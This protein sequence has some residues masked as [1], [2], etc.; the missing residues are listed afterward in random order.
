MITF[1]RLGVPLDFYDFVNRWPTDEELE[2]LMHPDPDSA[3]ACYGLDWE[4]KHLMQISTPQRVT[5]FALGRREARVRIAPALTALLRGPVPKLGFDVHQDLNTLRD[6]YPDEEAF[7]AVENLIDVQL[8]WK[9]SRGEKK[10]AG[11][12]T[13]CSKVL[14]R[15][16]CKALQRAAWD[17]PSMYTP[18]MLEYAALD[19]WCL[20]EIARV[21]PDLHA[22]K[23]DYPP[24]KHASDGDVV[25]RERFDRPE[26]IRLINE[27][28]MNAT[29]LR[30]A[31]RYLRSAGMSDWVEVR[32]TRRSTSRGW[33]RLEAPPVSQQNM[34]VTLRGAITRGM[35]TSL[36]VVNMHPTLVAQMGEA[37]GCPCPNVQEY[38][39]ARE[40][41]LTELARLMG[42]VERA[43]A[44]KEFLMA[45]YNKASEAY[46]EPVVQDV[47][48]LMEHEGITFED[49]NKRIQATESR[50]LDSVCAS[51]ES[52]C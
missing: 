14:G 31:R 1:L 30:F 34:P 44:K 19:A 3:P 47:R 5:L 20:T 25:K 29:E 4:G 9:K 40:E 28:R 17:R 13:V 43:R 50:I 6:A 51:A 33:M 24:P 37:C 12:S 35:Y 48:R 26:L 52:G 10:N 8:A 38:V 41:K 7:T 32:Y 27:N 18:E 49:L 36:D 16:L 11:L 2:N 21:C 39:D 42:G 15:P 23:C 22:I 46:T 45:L